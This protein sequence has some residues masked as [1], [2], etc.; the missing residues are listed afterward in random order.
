MAFYLLFVSFRAIPRGT[1]VFSYLCAQG[2]FL[3]DLGDQGIEPSLAACKAI[4]SLWPL[5]L[6]VLTEN[7]WI[8]KGLA[9]VLRLK[10]YCSS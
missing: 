2:L 8:G 3:E 6:I 10:N 1:K 4:L 9:G 5:N 7:P